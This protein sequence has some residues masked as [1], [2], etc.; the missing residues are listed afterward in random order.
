[1]NGYFLCLQLL[2][3]FWQLSAV[4]CVFDCFYYC[5]L[6]IV[7]PRRHCW[8]PSRQL[9][10]K[11]GVAPRPAGSD[12][13][14]NSFKPHTLPRYPTGSDQPFPSGRRTARIRDDQQHGLKLKKDGNYSIIDGVQRH[15]PVLVSLLELWFEGTWGEGQ[16]APA[17]TP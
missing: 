3:R 14:F 5:L 12:V 10:G 1:M 4:A 16:L 15:S 17:T 13:N 6:L 7:Q 9:G 11:L 8:L 2:A